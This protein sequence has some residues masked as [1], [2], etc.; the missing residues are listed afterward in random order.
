[1]GP[2]HSKSFLAG[3]GEMGERIRAFEW[4]KTRIGAAEQWPQSLRS[5]VSMMLASKAAL[6]VFWGP[7]YLCFYNDAYRPVF[8]AKHPEM[9]G[10]PG[11]IAWNEIWD[12]GV[13]LHALLD[14]VVETGE[15]FTAKDL[16]FVLER[17]GYMEETYF[18]VSYDPVRV[19]S[20]DVGGVFCIVTETTGRVVGERRLAL[21]RDLAACNASARDVSEACTLAAD[22]LATA[23]KDLTFALIY[24]DGSLQGSTPNAERDLACA[25]AS[26]VRKLEIGGVRL[27][28]G[29]NPE[30]PFDEQH[31]SFLNLVAGQI[32]TAIGNAKAYEEERKRAESLAELDRAKTVFFSNVSHEFR[33]PLTLMLGPLDDGLADAN[34]PLPA[35]QRE[36]QEVV[37]RNARRLLKMVNSL[38]DFSR[39]EAGRIEARFEATDLAALTLDLTSTFRSAIESAGLRLVVNTS[40]VEGLVYVDRGMWEKIV[41]NLLSNAFKFTLVGE[42]EVSLT[43]TD[44]FAVLVVRDTGSGIAASDLPHIFERFRRVEG[45]RGRTQE[46]TGIGL[47]LVQEL[48]RL[49]GGAVTVVSAPNEGSSFTVRIPRGSAHLPTQHIGPSQPE[50]PVAARAALFVDEA[51][52]WAPTL[53]DVDVPLS[54]SLS[55]HAER[56]GRIL[57]ADDNADMR[58]YVSRLLGQYYDVVAVGDGEAALREIRDR[59]P[60]LVLADVMMP[61]LDGFGLLKALRDDSE[62]RA[63]PVVLLSARAGEEARIEGMRAGA[64]DYLV[65]P[66][67]S[68][69]LIARIQGHIAMSRMRRQS[70]QQ[71]RT[72]RGEAEVAKRGSEVVEAQL[73]EVFDRAPAMICT[74]RGPHHVYESAN[75]RYLEVLGKSDLIGKT[76]AEGFPEVQDQGFI[77]LLDHV[78]STGTPYVANEA[79]IRIFPD[80][81]Q[82]M[83]EI[84]VN[85]VYQP[86]FDSAREVTGI[87]V[88]AVDVTESRQSRRLLERQTM[89]LEDARTRAEEANRVKAEFLATM[90]HELRTPLNGIMGYSDLLDAEIGGPVTTAQKAQIGRIRA[91]ARHLLQIIE[92]ILTFS[93][94]DAGREESHVEEVDVVQLAEE[95]CRLVEPLA[96]QKSIRFACETPNALTMVT[97]PGKLRQILL[98]LLSNAIKFTDKGEVRLTVSCNHAECTFEVRDTGSGILP[99]DSERIFEAFYQGNA[100]ARVRSGTGLGLSV[101]R[102][103]ARLLG[104]EITL[105]SV[106]GEGSTFVVS[107]P[108]VA[109]QL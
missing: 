82:T 44:E 2:L 56:S 27:V 93:R 5:Q 52:R 18:D 69:E 61:R 77:E 53:L 19:E 16:L 83:K 21:L 62:T 35:I 74:L 11:H 99:A 13:K 6:L 32:A 30:R 20:G 8:G 36:R 79:P 92:E 98:N 49:H 67:S 51:S 48:V 76:V 88:H 105:T 81:G 103:L 96:E 85:F 7:D 107:L 25:P 66:F 80:G 94:I 15:A 86:L 71:E 38:L 29:I 101:S 97:D 73:R 22:T 65:K 46:G 9:L 26:V 43:S 4:S 108:L 17:Y 89:E 109:G 45:T 75:A 78:Y 33:T 10:Q 54:L 3:G 28:V 64:D 42:I 55:E 39:I 1:M 84:F 104:G 23:K 100:G 50:E 87:L 63:L 72:L 68:R 40:G 91:G 37:R 59:P 95:A 12:S 24:V 90:S 41:L 14:G 70:L 47:A 34:H 31:Q 57:L 60:D 106:V 102:G 58:D